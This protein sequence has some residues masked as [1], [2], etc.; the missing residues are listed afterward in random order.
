MRR[1]Q[2]L[3]QQELEAIA[4]DTRANGEGQGHPRRDAAV[5]GAVPAANALSKAQNV[6]SP[7]KRPQQ[8]RDAQEREQEQKQEQAEDDVITSDNIL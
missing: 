6:G 4:E 2:H 3:A 8:T 5:R 7:K 1:L